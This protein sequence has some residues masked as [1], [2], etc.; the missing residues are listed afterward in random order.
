MLKESKRIFK[1]VLVLLL[2]LF[3]VSGPCATYATV[4][5]V[6]GWLFTFWLHNVV[7]FTSYRKLLWTMRE[8]STLLFLSLIWWTTWGI[9]SLLFPLFLCPFF[10]SFFHLF[11]SPSLLVILFYLKVL[12]NLK[13][14]YIHMYVHICLGM[15]TWV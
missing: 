15:C 8:H 1:L 2:W 4:T 14:V 7:N 10:H 11:I 13:N 9:S 6:P 12:F 3:H 5:K